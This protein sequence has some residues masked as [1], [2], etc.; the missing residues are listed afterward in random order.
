M[1]HTCVHVFNII[2][3]SYNYIKV[4]TRYIHLSHPY[5]C[6]CFFNQILYT[7]KLKIYN[8]NQCITVIP[9]PY[10][11]CNA[12]QNI[13]NMTGQTNRGYFLFTLVLEEVCN[14]FTNFTATDILHCME[15]TRPGLGERSTTLRPSKPSPKHL[16]AVIFITS[17][18]CPDCLQDTVFDV[19]VQSNSVPF[20]CNTYNNFM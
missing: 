18:G 20:A 17:I 15:H 7:Y 13:M 1:W 8:A 19:Q 14:V 16:A 10:R 3:I 2:C 6:Q 11:T 12:V 5:A 9:T 4:I